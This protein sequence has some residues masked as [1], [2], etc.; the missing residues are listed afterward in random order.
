MAAATASLERE[1]RKELQPGE[2]EHV[3]AAAFWSIGVGI[4]KKSDFEFVDLP[5]TVGF[6]ELH[7]AAA[8][9]LTL[10]STDR[11]NRSFCTR[12]WCA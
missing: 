3:R 2:H 8:S 7:V 12:C 4:R 11:S 6:K 10:Y 1:L 9:L 5:N